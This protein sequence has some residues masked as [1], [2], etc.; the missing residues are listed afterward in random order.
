MKHEKNT[1]KK[2]VLADEEVNGFIYYGCVLECHSFNQELVNG[3]G[4]FSR[5]IF[6]TNKEVLHRAENFHGIVAER[7]QN[8]LERTEIGSRKY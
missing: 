8:G 6:A 3:S 4:S 7:C 1:R 2:Q 5:L